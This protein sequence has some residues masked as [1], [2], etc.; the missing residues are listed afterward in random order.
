MWVLSSATC[1]TRSSWT[2]QGG[3]GDPANLPARRTRSRVLGPAYSRHLVYKAL[4]ERVSAGGGRARQADAEPVTTRQIAGSLRHWGRFNHSVAVC[5]PL[6]YPERDLPVAP[7]TFGCWLGDGTT[8]S[9]GF[10]CADE[11]ILDQI[12][13]DGYVVTH[14]A[15]TRMQ[16]TISNR[17]ERERRI[18]EALDFAG[19]G[20]SVGRAALQAGAGLSAVFQA[21][22]AASRGTKGLCC[23]VLTSP[24][25]LPDASRI[26]REVG[27]K[28]IPEAYL[29]ASV[30]QRRALLAG[31]R[32]RT[33][34][35]IRRNGR[36][37]GH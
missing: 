32:T 3:P 12:R 31:L 29:H 22:E 13:E 5:R 34:I 35:A 10:T 6:R 17:P 33:A 24:R 36:V 15:S 21:A 30:S 19:Q 27:V 9:A 1:S 7:Y 18:A 20:M 2:C 4:A 8:M 23:S 37:H 28:H 14:H 25:A 26:F 16:Y 11:E